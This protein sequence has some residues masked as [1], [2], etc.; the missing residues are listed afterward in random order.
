MP[1]HPPATAELPSA[2]LPSRAA[3]ATLA[4]WRRR[5]PAAHRRPG[6][7]ELLQPRRDAP[8]ARR[9][10]PGRARSWRPCSVTPRRPGWANSWR[11]PQ[12]GLP[13][14]RITLADGRGAL[15]SCWQVARDLALRVQ[16]D[17]E[18]SAPGGRA[19]AAAARAD[20]GH[21]AHAVGLALSG[22]AAGRRVP[23]GG[24]ERCL[25]RF[26][27][28][29]ARGA[30]RHRP[31]AAAARG[32]PAPRRSM[33]GANCPS[34]W[35]AGPCRLLGEQRL[36][37]ASGPRTLEPRLGLPGV[38]RRGP[39]L[40]A[41]RA[42]G[43]HRRTCGARAGRPLAGRTGAVVRPEPDRHAGVRRGRA[44]R[45]LQPGLRG[46]GRS[47]AGAAE[48]RVARTA[49]AAGLGRWRAAQGAAARRA[50]AGKPCRRCR[51]PTAGASA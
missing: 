45:A 23:A 25:P 24:G 33:R 31:A 38:G 18:R 49:G 9:A 2:L 13:S 8:V 22:D 4:G 3:L 39:A 47:G 14:L 36:L 20:A 17:A 30:A 27:R 1:I 6:Q 50:A 26:H 51:C 28:T 7:P 35:P 19:A 11:S 32:R 44:D 40:V 10:G 37:D 5:R 29:H 16:F 42:A 41:V 43:L 48:R 12:P 15:L 21:A 34:G 46:A